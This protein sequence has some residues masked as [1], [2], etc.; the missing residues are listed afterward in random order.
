MKC[1]RRVIFGRDY[2]V[3]IAPTQLRVVKALLR[4]P[5]CGPH[6]EGELGISRDIVVPFL[7]GLA[8]QPDLVSL[9]IL[10][11]LGI[12]LSPLEDGGALVLPGNL[13]L[14]SLLCS[15]S[16]VLSLPLTA[17]ENS[18]RDSWEL[19]IRHDFS[20]RSESSNIS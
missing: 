9:L 12:L 18:F 1:V 14:N 5:C 13:E 8:P 7:P 4:P 15:V 19:S 17:L 11:F 10:I 6:H 20:C 2:G 3:E 16:P